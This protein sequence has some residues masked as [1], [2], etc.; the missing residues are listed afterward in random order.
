VAGNFPDGGEAIAARFDSIF[1]ALPSGGR[2]APSR[3]VGKG[4][5][6]P[7]LTN[8][9][10]GQLYYRVMLYYGELTEPERRAATLLRM[11]LLGGMGSRILGAARRRGL[12]Y[13]VGGAGHAEP[14][15]SSFGFAGYVTN[16]NAGELFE[17][18]VREY[19]DVRAGH[20]SK[21]ELEASKDLMVGSVKR[22]T[23][24]ASDIMGWYMEPYEE[25]GEI[26]D[27]D[28]TLE[29]VRQV[30]ADEVQAAAEKATASHRVGQ[31]YLGRIG[32]AD[33]QSYSK[34]MEPLW[35]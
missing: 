11:L 15:N 13:S 30:R 22:S 27:F 29:Q 33:G 7:I 1:A 6:A 18:A 17:L 21:A 20:I 5:K 16:E 31:S 23:Q 3:K 8:R 14:G 28:L 19:S 12:A 2:L 34:T 10:I 26:R 25:S 9:D 24:T 4:L 32:D 35:S